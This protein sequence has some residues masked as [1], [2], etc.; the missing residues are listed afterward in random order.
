MARVRILLEKEET[1]EEVEELLEKAIKYKSEGK[2]HDRES[3]DDESM[4]PL[5]KYIEDAFEKTY[6]AILKDIEKVLDGR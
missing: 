1:L 4:I 3:F 6:S 5:S 2:V